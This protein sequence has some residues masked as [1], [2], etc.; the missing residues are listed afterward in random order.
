MSDSVDLPPAEEVSVVDDTSVTADERAEIDREI[1][2]LVASADA[3]ATLP[4][5]FLMPQ[6]SG[7]L[8]PLLIW[9][10]A[11]GAF[12]GGFLYLQNLFATRESD[13]TIESADFFSTE[14]QVIEQLIRESEEALAAKEEEITNI[15]GRLVQLSE[16]RANLEE[17]LE[18][19]V[20]QREEQLRAELAQELEAERTRLAGQG[21]SQAQ[22][23]ARIAEIEAARQAEVDAQLQ[24][25]RDEAEQQLTDL[26]T[27]L[28]AQEAQLEQT[29]AASE[30]ELGRL[31]EEA[32][33]RE[34]EL[35]AEF[36]AEIAELEEA[37]QQAL[38]EL[39]QL[40][41]RQEE[42]DLLTDRVLGSFT[43]VVQDIEEGLTEEALEGLNSLERLLLNE[44][45]G[46]AD[47]Q[48]RRQTELALA[49][50]LRGL[51]QEVDVLRQNLTLRD[52]TTSDE[53]EAQLEQQRAAE[54]IQTAADTVA[55]AE[56]AR[57]GGRFTEA[58]SLYRQALETIPSLDLVYPGILELESTRREVALQSG[59]AEAQSLLAA[60]SSAQAI[61]RYLESVTTI[62]AD[63][64]DPL[65]QVVQGI[66]RAV[67][68]NNEDFLESQDELQSE[69]QAQISA[70]Q[71][72]ITT[73]TRDLSAAQNAAA[74]AQET[75]S[76]LET[77]LEDVEAERE[78]Q[79]ELAASRSV[80]LTT[81]NQQL[82]DLTDQL[83]TQETAVT[84]A[85][86]RADSFQ[87]SLTEA[88][89]SITDLEGRIAQLQQD[90]TQTI[91]ARDSAIESLAATAAETDAQLA[92]LESQIATLEEQLAAA[93]ENP[94]IVETVPE[95][96]QEQL[97]ALR[98]TIAQRDDL[99]SSQ[100]N[101]L[102]A[103]QNTIDGLTTS[104]EDLQARLDDTTGELQTMRGTETELQADLQAAQAQIDGLQ[105][106][107][108][109]LQ[110]T[111][112][113]TA[114]EA[115]ALESEVEALSSRVGELEEIESDLETLTTRVE[116]ALSTA[117]AQIANGNY[118]LARSQ[119]LIP[120]QQAP[121]STIFPGL[122]TNL[123]T[124]HEGALTDAESLSSGDARAGAFTDVVDLATQVQQ[125]IDA[126]ADAASVQSFLRREPDIAGVADELF[127]IVELS[128][129]AISAPEIEY[130]LL[131][132]ISR[133]ASDL[134][135]VERL[136]ALEAEVG[137]SIQIR[138]AEG[139]GEEIPVANG[140]ILEVTDRRVVTRIDEIL[141]LDQ[142]PEN[143]DLV[144]I[145]Q[146]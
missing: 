117:Q 146:E 5:E 45:V 93:V 33:A 101:E 39:E 136:V 15:Q 4:R 92:T 3:E 113:A 97:D 139:L 24:T 28:A 25:F 21:Q 119:I 80:E 8:L 116:R 76:A 110:D 29:L 40:Q 2:K 47:R 118:T 126:P 83:A 22:I 73:L 137:D 96:T 77:E 143:R 9:V 20:A 52:L 53:E 57:E 1:D 69:L 66:D 72:E 129:R 51:V 37:E 6:R 133:V 104:L 55:L 125:N 142:I 56:A 82:D 131:G 61:S 111:R 103:R 87:A 105:E 84:A 59:L 70:R 19:E 32:A 90:L 31:Q 102:E 99:V 112:S 12:A 54:L 62:A 135:I 95:E 27:Q 98:Q 114:S 14:S 60:G 91:A 10:I 38:A 78:E 124:A 134:V 127:E 11:G 74:T 35:R 44:G 26:Q 79:S 36:T 42:E 122:V 30:E 100:R 71:N 140:T 46:S 107:I 120:F 49:G 130:Q 94:E 128:A 123:N 75:I 23:D 106:Q 115:D 85:Q 89:G 138:R 88:Q 41:Q 13:I 63:E 17:N 141:E 86:S 64:D 81:L 68:A 65:L 18:A 145:A 50:T 16:E 48:R 121:G 108:A 132:S 109:G 34:E 7:I 67:A 43:V 58:R 144:Y